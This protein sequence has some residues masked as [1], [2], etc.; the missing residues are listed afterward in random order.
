MRAQWVCSRV[1]NIA[2]WTA[3]RHMI[4][5]DIYGARPLLS[6]RLYSMQTLYSHTDLGTGYLNVFSDWLMLKPTRLC[7]RGKEERGE[8][9]PLWPFC[10]S[11][12]LARRLPP[13]VFLPHSLS[14]SLPARWPS[15]AHT[16]EKTQRGACFADQNP[17]AL[18]PKSNALSCL[19]LPLTQIQWHQLFWPSF[20]PNPMTSAFLTFLWPR[21]N[22]ISFFDLPLTQIQCPQLF[23]P[24][25]DP[26]LM[27]SAFLTFLWPKSNALSFFD[28]P[29]TQIQC[30]QLFW[31]SFDPNPMTPAFS[32]FL[33]PNPMSSAFL[34][35]FIP[36]FDPNP[37]SS[38]FLTFLWP[39]SYIQSHIMHHHLKKKK[40]LSFDPNPMWS[41][42]FILL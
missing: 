14:G 33:D 20:D 11:W 6:S 37:M 2:I 17:S 24:S 8:N 32:T 36:S 1:E 15:G 31:P 30:P 7:W 25:F 29:L 10:V 40:S 4:F 16:G 22:D 26:N 19:D 35:F 42:F 34:N 38:A 18:W 39:F 3:L 21:S 9:L 23:W 28:L 27:P 12:R 41:A 13:A 5:E